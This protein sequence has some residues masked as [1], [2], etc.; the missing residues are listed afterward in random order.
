MEDSE[1][2]QDELPEVLALIGPDTL[3]ILG[4]ILA[5]PT[6]NHWTHATA[7]ESIGKVALQRPETCAKAVNLLIE[8][9]KR[10]EELP[11]FAEDDYELNAFMIISLTRLKAQEA[12]PV[13]ERAFKAEHVDEMITGPWELTQKEFG[14]IT[15]EEFDQLYPPSPPFSLFESFA[16]KFDDREPP[17][18]F[19]PSTT[20]KSKYKNLATTKKTKQKMAQKS[21]KKN[22]KH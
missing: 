20:G 22:R 13:I 1:W 6:R 2:A 11:S 7:I 8:Q 10:M 3:S 21:R 5:D 4:S 18:P 17:S 15:Q 19:N 16:S 9:M 12:L 14:L